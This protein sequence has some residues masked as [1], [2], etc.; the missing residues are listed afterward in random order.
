MTDLRPNPTVD[1]NIRRVLSHLYGIN[2]L[3]IRQ[4]QTQEQ[5]F[6]LSFFSQNK[7]CLRAYSVISN[8]Q[9]SWSEISLSLFRSLDF[10]ITNKF[11]ESKAIFTCARTLATSLGAR[12]RR[13][14]LNGALLNWD[15][16]GDD[17]NSP[18]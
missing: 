3:S 13:T 5:C 4:G 9:Y 14:G 8:L 16:Y 2:P 18:H 6:L 10:V 12:E 7:I 11:S 15:P 17:S 1:G